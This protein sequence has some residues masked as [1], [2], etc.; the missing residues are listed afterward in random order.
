MNLREAAEAAESA[1]LWCISNGKQ[2]HDS[3]PFDVLTLQ[4]QERLRSIILT[5]VP[6]QLQATSAGGKLPASPPTRRGRTPSG[7][8]LVDA[9]L[10]GT[11]SKS[12]RR[13]QVSWDAACNPPGEESPLSR[14]WK[15]SRRHPEGTAAV[16]QAPPTHLHPPLLLRFKRPREKLCSRGIHG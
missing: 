16:T 5:L 9:R 6:V 14:S 12:R 4:P 7:I 2:H 8:R 1:A 3:P 10:P 13:S 11:S 15:I